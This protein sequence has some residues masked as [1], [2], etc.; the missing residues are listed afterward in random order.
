MFGLL[1][2]TTILIAL[3]FVLLHN[4]KS[5]VALYP[6]ATI[7]TQKDDF[8][9]HIIQK[10]ETLHL[11]SKQ[12]NVKIDDILAANPGLSVKTFNYGKKIR[13]PAKNTAIVD[14]KVKVTPKTEPQ[15]PKAMIP[16]PDTLTNSSEKAEIIKTE[17]INIPVVVTEKIQTPENSNFHKTQE[18]NIIRF[19]VDLYR[20]LNK[21]ITEKELTE[22]YKAFLKMYVEQIVGIGKFDSGEIFKQFNAFFSEPTL[23]S[24]YEDTE[25]KFKDIEFISNEL[26]P[27]LEI[28]FREFPRM[29]RPSVYTHISGLNQSVVVTDDVLSISL[30]KYM[31]ADYPFYKNYFKSH[32]LQNMTPE[33]IVP[34]YLLGF[35]MANFS[36]QGRN[37][38]LM[39]KMI[40]EGKLRYILTRLLPNRKEWECLG[41][42]EEQYIW[43]TTNQT[44][45][46]KNI[47]RSGHLYTPDYMITSKYINSAPYTATISTESPGGVGIWV[48]FQIVN[49]YMKDHPETSFFQLM[50]IL[51]SR[52]LLIDSKYKP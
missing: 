13:I 11:L 34:D 25:H 30:D 42:T 47:L 23:M 36:F 31:G 49:V 17:T 37:D 4:V 10:G 29:A 46:W 51:D 38:I 45:I 12:Y 18:S 2:H 35:M 1:K 48:G 6:D 39:E 33:R 3:L 9:S 16:S 19:D 20:Y 8:V 27:A 52:Q 15:K 32:Q 40:Y 50:N 7:F 14:S 43:C 24:L 21:Q 28:L 44:Q 22:N 26:N 5:E 41:Y